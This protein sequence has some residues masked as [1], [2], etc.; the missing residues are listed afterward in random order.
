MQEIWGKAPRKTENNTDLRYRP[1]NPKP[2]I[3]FIFVLSHL[4]LKLQIIS[5][6]SD[7]TDFKLFSISHLFD[8]TW[9]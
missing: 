9:T 4:D 6:L 1:L 7:H 3:H 5:Y 8:H 2:Q